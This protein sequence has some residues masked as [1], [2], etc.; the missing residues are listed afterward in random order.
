M[1]RIL[2]LASSIFMF[3][4]L[5]NAQDDCIPVFPDTKGAQIVTKSYT[6]KNELLTTTTYT[7]TASYGGQSGN[8]TDMNFTVV[9]AKGKTMDQGKIVLSCQDG[10]FYMNMSHRYLLPEETL[11]M[12][13]SSSEFVA[14]YLDYP[15]TFAEGTPEDQTFAMDDAQYTLTSKTDKKDFLRVSVRNRKY[16]KSERITTPAGTFNAAKVTFIFEVYTHKTKTTVQY[17]GIEWY[18]TKV[19]IVRSETRDAKGN[20]LNYTV[21][22]SLK[23]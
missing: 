11:K 20:L 1:K 16:E 6:A 3:A 12:L 4:G 9:D 7:V 23:K 21:I 22:D 15:N 8:D 5:S 10:V 19:G 13:S 17:K 14:D 2:L 18:S